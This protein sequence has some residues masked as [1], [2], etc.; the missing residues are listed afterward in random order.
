M[1]EFTLKEAAEISGASYATIRQDAAR[2]KLKVTKDGNRTTVSQVDLHAYMASKGLRKLADMV[3][4]GAEPAKVTAEVR[5]LGNIWGNLDPKLQG[6]ILDGI[7]RTSN[8]KVSGGNSEAWRRAT[9]GRPEASEIVETS[10][11]PHFGH[12]VGY[13]HRS[14]P[15]WGRTSESTWELEGATYSWN[16]FVWEGGGRVAGRVIED[17]NISP[18]APAS[19]RRPLAPSKAVAR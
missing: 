19:D 15:K 2:G 5:E 6:A 9:R 17:D 4:A 16:G 7:P 1:P 8:G 3:E 11:D 18:A 10:D 14:N 13:R 12:P